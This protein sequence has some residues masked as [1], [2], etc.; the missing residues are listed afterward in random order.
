MFAWYCESV[1]FVQTVSRSEM[2]VDREITIKID[3][4]PISGLHTGRNLKVGG[5]NVVHES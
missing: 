1:L 5:R 2:S 4:G 3:R